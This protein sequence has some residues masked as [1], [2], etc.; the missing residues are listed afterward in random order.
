MM[1][2]IDQIPIV[3]VSYNS[4]DLIASLLGTLR[5][6]YPSNP[7]FII[8]GSAPEIAEQIAPIAAQFEQVRFIPFGYNI[9]HGP[10]MAWAI[11][12]LGLSGPVL[13][14]DSDVEV[15][16]RG[17]LESLAEHLEPHLYGVGSV[18]P[19]DENGFTNGPNPMPYLHPACMLTNIEVVRQWPLP[20]KH[21][22]P[23]LP[24]MMA[25][26]KAGQSDLLRNVE[27]L[28]NDF[29]PTPAQRIFLRHD[30]QG[31][32]RRTG[33]YHYDKPSTATVDQELLAIVPKAVKLVHVGAGDGAFA[34]AYK[35]R[36]PVCNYF[37]IEG[38]LIA[39]EQARAHCDFVY[40][41]DI[42]TPDESRDR[43]MAQ[44]DC[45]LLDGA[46]ERARDPWTL[47]AMV[48]ASMA[49]QGTLVVSV[50]NFQNWSNLLRLAVGDYRYAEDGVLRR[51]ELRQYTRGSLLELLGQAGFRLTGGYAVQGGDA[52]NEGVLPI[53]RQLAQ[54]V[55]RDPELV[56]QDAQ[57]QRFIL[58]ATPA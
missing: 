53:L 27:W 1:L 28:H 52:I 3:A 23:M 33:G 14:L 42:E 12:N 37:G 4:P 35:Q 5:K 54:L 56:L 40:Q 2:N 7:V 57:P 20:V 16:K 24:P 31:T 58:L 11:E 29:A 46:L 38:D 50:R 26:A 34:K 51:D 25:L 32:V 43:Q 15:L 44:A 30:W 18:A 19:V 45:W 48:R 10:G 21:G 22:A 36:H 49:P 47:L 6:F 9:H 55:G 17:F 8:D 13:F 41:Q 39:A